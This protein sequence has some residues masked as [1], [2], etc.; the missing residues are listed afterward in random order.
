MFYATGISVT[1]DVRPIDTLAD[2]MGYAGILG[3]PLYSLL[4]VVMHKL[5]A[6]YTH[7]AHE[8]Y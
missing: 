3:C 1:I 7:D 8:G 5:E 4:V 2:P 6:H